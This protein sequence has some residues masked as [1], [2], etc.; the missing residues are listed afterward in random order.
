MQNVCF[1][2]VTDHSLEALLFSCFIF[3]FLPEMTAWFSF[4][5]SLTHLSSSNL[6]PSGYHSTTYVVG[7]GAVSGFVQE[8][9]ILELLAVTCKLL[10]DLAEVKT[11]Q[12][13]SHVIHKC[14]DQCY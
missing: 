5:P 9:V 4:S 14:R 6:L 2:K 10:G 3:H 1:K 12:S 11:R 13:C 8:M 7:G